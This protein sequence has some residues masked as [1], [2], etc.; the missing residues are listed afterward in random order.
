MIELDN[1]P[2][3]YISLAGLPKLVTVTGTHRGP[4]LVFK[5]VSGHALRFSGVR[6]YSEHEEDAICFDGDVIGADISAPHTV[7]DGAITFWGRLE[8]VSVT[9]FKIVGAHTGIR[10]TSALA[11]KNV[12]ICRNTIENASH[13]GIYIGP[14]YKSE[15][16]LSHVTISGNQV[17][18]CGWDGIQVGNTAMAHIFENRVHRCGLAR[19]PGQDYGIT[20]N[21]GCLAFVYD[22]EVTGCAKSYQFLDSR[23]FSHP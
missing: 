15:P 9:G 20:I 21:P 16:Q 22:N 6:I 17:S 13:E 14:S 23:V 12:S 11:H 18:G 19:K 1:I 4:R 5:E 7:L 3:P 2:S 10:C 8:N